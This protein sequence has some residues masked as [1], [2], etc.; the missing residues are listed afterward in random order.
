MYRFLSVSLSPPWQCLRY[1]TDMAVL[2][3]RRQLRRV[4]Q[5]ERHAVPGAARRRRAAAGAGVIC[6]YGRARIG[7]RREGNSYDAGGR[8]LRCAP[9]LVCV[10]CSWSKVSIATEI[11]LLAAAQSAQSH[12]RKCLDQQ[13]RC[14]SRLRGCFHTTPLPL[15]LMLRHIL[16]GVHL[17]VSA[18]AKEVLAAWLLRCDAPGAGSEGDGGIAAA[19]GGDGSSSSSGRNCGMSHQWLCSRAP[20]AGGMRRKS[21]PQVAHRPAL[22]ILPRLRFVRVSLCERGNRSR[23]SRDRGSRP[24]GQRASGHHN[25]SAA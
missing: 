13:L 9:V 10:F 22:V 4:G 24:P 8:Q 15:R 14:T 5:R 7:H 19:A 17:L 6:Q 1:T 20:P 23:C 12:V 18:G 25:E 21:T 2:S 11:L 3:T 16:A